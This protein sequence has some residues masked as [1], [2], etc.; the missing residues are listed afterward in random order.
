[1]II[2]KDCKVC[3]GTGKVTEGI[4]PECQFRDLER[5]ALMMKIDMRYPV[6]PER[7]AEVQEL[8]AQFR[9]PSRLHNWHIELYKTDIIVRLED[10]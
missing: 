9:E 1:M 2:K 10:F 7:Q 5:K 8:A 4:C 6:R 3:H